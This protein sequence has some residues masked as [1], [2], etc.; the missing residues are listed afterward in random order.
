MSIFVDGKHNETIVYRDLSSLGLGLKERINSSTIGIV[1]IGFIRPKIKFTDHRLELLGNVIVT[2]SAKWAL[3]RAYE[4]TEAPVCILEIDQQA[5]PCYA[6]INGFGVR[7]AASQY[8]ALQIQTETSVREN[9]NNNENTISSVAQKILK[10]I[11]KPLNKEEIFAHIIQE[12]LYSFGAKRPIEVLGVELNRNT[13]GSDYS[14][15]SESPCFGKTADDRFFCVDECPNVEMLGWLKT[16][17]DEVPQIA[18]EL[19][20]YGVF[21]E[22]SLNNNVDLLPPALL[23]ITDVYRYQILKPI[24]NN[25]DPHSLLKILPKEVLDVPISSLRFPVRVENVLNEQNLETLRDVMPFNKLEMLRWNNFGR[26]SVNDFCSKIIE[27]CDKLVDEVLLQSVESLTLQNDTDKSE[28]VDTALKMEVIEKKPLIEH[29][30][31]ALFKLGDKERRIIEQRTGASSPVLTLQAVADKMDITR[32]RVRQIQKKYVE[33]IIRE[34]YWDDCIAI[35]IGQLL[36]SR[37]DPLFLEML[38]LEDEWFKGFIGNY[39]HLKAIIELFSESQIRIINAD[40]SNI[41]TRIKQD[42]W[43][44]SVISL[45][46]SLKDKADEKQWTRAEIEMLLTSHLNDAGAPELTGLLFKEFDDVLQFNGE[47]ETAVLIAF[48]KS[49]E[50]AVTAVLEQ[51]ESPL[52]YSEV[53][54]RASEILGK[55]V[56]DRR[57]QNALVAQRAK[58]YGRGI[59]GLER[60]NPLSERMCN[61]IRLVV[62]KMMYQ[63][64]PM[65]QWHSNGILN[66]LREQFPSLPEELDAYV[67]NIILEKED[68]LS[69]LNRMV[70]ARTDS[71]QCP[72]DR[73][74]MADAFTKLLEENGAPMMGSD[75]RDKLKEIRGVGDGQQIQPND[76]MIQ[77]GPELWGLIERD[78]GASQAENTRALDFLEVF[79]EKQQKGIHISEIEG[80]MESFEYSNYAEPYALFNLA[81]RDK[82]FYLAKAMYLGLAS[83]DGDVRR[84]NLTQAVKKVIEEMSDPMPLSK[85][86]LLVEDYTGL[87]QEGSIAGLLIN[88]NAVFDSS[89]KTWF[90]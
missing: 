57:A 80:V 75:L 72:D 40:G 17:Q 66:K 14:K 9:N 88:N 6:I 22:G 85:I 81:Q 63:G 59:Y 3:P 23:K 87:K 53:A 89:T 38:E 90:K 15:A 60:F 26:K 5:M 30:E 32:E 55:A 49:A 20:S 64:P 25:R 79:L 35:K 45:R 65:R 47:G 11:G 21:D 37:K 2:V 68:R 58:L 78:T 56:D 8:Q 83:W 70:W 51:A 44:R 52:H 62:S 12:D 86:Q 61:N 71:K 50:S 77:V 67:L 48:G 84:L 16:L 24:T 43:D 27:I 29:F 42:T 7:L 69:Y 19:I 34:E 18:S 36:A 13:V 4:A 82:R 41:V 76:R 39:D 31:D 54:K 33:K 74:D 1:H 10:K 73:I 28:E 46:N